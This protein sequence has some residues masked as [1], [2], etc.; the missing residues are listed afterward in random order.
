MMRYL[1][2]S[3]LFIPVCAYAWEGGLKTGGDLLSWLLSTLVV[4]A[5]IVI[6]AVAVKKTRIKFG[7]GGRMQILSSV[8]VGPKEKVVELKIGERVILL[9][10]ASGNVS[11]LY[12]L[13]LKTQAKAPEHATFEQVLGQATKDQAESKKVS[14]KETSDDGKKV[15]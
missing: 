5:V 7:S 8:S 12:D 2:S 4:L 11:F 1:L 13:S 3:G 6:L 9:G 10:V 14:L 15:S